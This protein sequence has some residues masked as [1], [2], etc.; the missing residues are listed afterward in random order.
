MNKR[1]KILMGMKQED[2][3]S[4]VLL[5]GPRTMDALKD[6]KEAAAFFLDVEKERLHL[7]PDFMLCGIEE[8]KKTIGVDTAQEILVF[9]SMSPSVA[10]VRVVII[11]EMNKMTIE[12]QNKLLK[13]IEESRVMVIGVSYEDN[14]LPTIKSRCR[15]IR[16]EPT[17]FAEYAASDASLADP[18]VYYYAS[19]GVLGAETDKKLLETY[20]RVKEAVEKRDKNALFLSLG[21]VSEKDRNL[22]FSS[23]RKQIGG[24]LSLIGHC[25]TNMMLV[26]PE[27]EL[28]SRSLKLISEHKERCDRLQYS[29]DDFFLCIAGIL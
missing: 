29:K 17:T 21:L 14:L 7:H 3:V 12:A 8:G 28:I 5:I 25:L 27:D 6:A 23:Y 24:T 2:F 16:Y 19:G 11:N 15:V 1:L 9:A 18:V 26:S 22:F 4:S 10:K 20:Q 13:L